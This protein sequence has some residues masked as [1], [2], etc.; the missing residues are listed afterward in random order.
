VVIAGCVVTK[1]AAANTIDISAGAYYDPANST[2][3]T[4]AAQT[5]VNAGTLGASQWNQVYITGTATVVVT[6]NADPPSTT[7]MGG[8]RKDGSNRRWI[9]SFRTDGSSNIRAQDVVA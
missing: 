1:H 5:G 2:V 7:Y 9:G 3:Q 8:A 4:F 6:N